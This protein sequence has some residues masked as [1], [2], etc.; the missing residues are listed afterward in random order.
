[1]KYNA[2]RYIMYAWIAIFFSC[3]KDAPNSFAASLKLTQEGTITVS[4]DTTTVSFGD[5]SV[6]ITNTNTCFP[7]TE[8]FSFTAIGP[9]LPA[10]A[11]YQ[12]NFG[13]G[14]TAKGANTT[15]S[16]QAAGSFLV[17]LF[18]MQDENTQVSKLNFPIKVNGKQ[19]KI[20]PSFTIKSDFPANLNFITFN[21]TSAVNQGD[22]ASYQ[23]DW[24]DSTSS[25]LSV[26]LTRHEFPTQIN[27]KVYPVKLTLTSNTGC[28]ADTT[29]HVTVPG[30]FNNIRGNFIANA[31]DQCTNEYF[32]FTAAAENVPG[33]SVYAWDFSDG[34]GI[35]TGNPI[36]YQYKFPNDYDII[37]IIKLNGREIY[38]THKLV[39]AK[40]EN[41]KPTAAFEQTLVWQKPTEVRWSFNS[42]STIPTSTIDSY[43]WSFG[44][45]VT[46]NTFLS[47]I[48]NT[49][50]RETIDKTYRVQ[51]I[52]TGNGCADTTFKNIT[53][54][55][56]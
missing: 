16:Y 28:K 33:G 4:K 20:V 40:G 27:D 5:I 2:L 44:N 54:P 50:T 22:F 23:W 21:S 19:T 35:Q 13:D 10:G 6:R 25:L 49:F 47:F 48:E 24:G 38:R 42:R 41:P 3:K 37:M 15:Y 46:N 9:A 11:F 1:M 51:L 7:S 36:R 45:G 31:F 18:L 56:L 52:V 43:Q 8:L 32:M 34:K 55:K 30:R 29:I 39:N 14:N 17:S 12:W 53:V 26:P